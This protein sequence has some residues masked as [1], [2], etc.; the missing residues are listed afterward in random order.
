M[1]LNYYFLYQILSKFLFHLSPK[2]KIKLF[3]TIPSPSQLFS[4]YMLHILQTSSL[5]LL[6]LYDIL[7]SK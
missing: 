5:T 4:I 3:L 2:E 7:D 1:E 6:K